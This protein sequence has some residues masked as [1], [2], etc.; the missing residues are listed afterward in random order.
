MEMDIDNIQTPTIEAEESSLGRDLLRAVLATLVITVMVGVIYPALV[1]GIGQAAFN[2]QAN[3]SLISDS[4][5]KVIGSE[6]IGQSFSQPQYFRGRP[7]AASTSTYTGTNGLV[8]DV[9][10][11]GGSNYGPT[12][13]RLIDPITGTVAINAQAV[14][15]DDFSTVASLP[16]SPADAAKVPID[17]V[18]TSASGL[19]PHITPAAAEVQIARVAK[20][21]GISEDALRQLVRQ[22]TDGRDLGIFGEP[23]VNV[24]KLNLALDSLKR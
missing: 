3:G 24:L 4:S 18:T 7:S 17:L 2:K 11:S 15:S 13:A 5:G 14:L 16:L 8:A 12:D 1:W 20:A 6:I 9:T 10:T 23:R 22:Y 19:D 21:R